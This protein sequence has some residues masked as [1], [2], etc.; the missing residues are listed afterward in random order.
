MLLG[1]F[2]CI[3]AEQTIVIR[4]RKFLYKF[5]VINNALCH[6]FVVNAIRLNLNRVAQTFS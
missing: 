2:N 4:K 5:S 3:Q 6:I 1:M